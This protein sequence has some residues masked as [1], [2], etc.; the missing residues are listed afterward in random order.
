VP[1]AEPTRVVVVPA[2]DR[3]DG[4]ALARSL[5]R[6]DRYAF[7]LC[8]TAAAALGAL[9]GELGARCVVFVGDVTSDDDRGALDALVAE[10]FAR[11]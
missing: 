11:A 1:A 10:L 4:A 3:P 8:G 2:A 6:S 7:V 9:A 5:A